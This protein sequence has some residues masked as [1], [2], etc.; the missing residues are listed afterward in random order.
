LGSDFD[1]SFSKISL[2]TKL[3]F[4]IAAPIYGLCLR[5]FASRH[6]I[7]NRQNVDIEKDRSEILLES[8]D[9]NEIEAVLVGKRDKVILQNLRKIITKNR[10]REIDIAIVYGAEHMRAILEYLIN[11]EKYVVIKSEWLTAIEL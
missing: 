1:K 9:W 8:S 11:V 10:L 6:F 4:L 5:Y 3:F 2:K 7:A